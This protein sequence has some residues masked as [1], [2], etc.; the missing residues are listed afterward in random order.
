MRRNFILKIVIAGFSLILNS[1]LWA[2]SHNSVNLHNR[3]PRKTIIN[4]AQRV[5]QNTINDSTNVLLCDHNTAFITID[6]H[7]ASNEK[8][9]PYMITVDS[10]GI[11]LEIFSGTSCIYNEFFE[12]KGTNFN[13]IKALANSANLKLAELHKDS[14]ATTENITLNFNT[15][16]QSYF[17]VMCSDGMINYSGNFHGFIDYIKSLIP[18]FNEIINSDYEDPSDYTDGSVYINGVQDKWRTITEDKGILLLKVDSILYT[19]DKNEPKLVLKTKIS[20]KEA[21]H[22]QFIETQHFNKKRKKL[23]YYG[24]SYE[25]IVKKSKYATLVKTTNNGITTIEFSL[26]SITPGVYAIYNSNTNWAI[27]VEVKD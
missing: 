12:Y 9:F 27:I 23:N 16:I 22:L 25:D 24:F 1:T 5:L 8:G 10:L 6:V 15:K 19:A 20:S 11:L 26:D 18:N 21:E 17:S 2:Q 3:L 13:K 14:L 4:A 7:S